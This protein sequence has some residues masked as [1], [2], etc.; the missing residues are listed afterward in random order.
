MSQTQNQDLPVPPASQSNE[1]QQGLLNLQRIMDNQLA[2]ERNSFLQ[3]RQMLDREIKELRKYRDVSMVKSLTVDNDSL[4]TENALLKKRLRN[5]NQEQSP[6]AQQTE[7]QSM[8][9]TMTVPTPHAPSQRTTVSTKAK[10][11]IKM[12]EEEVA[13]PEPEEPEETVQASG[14]PKDQLTLEDMLPREEEAQSEEPETEEPETEAAD[15]AEE[16]AAEQTEEPETEEPEAADEA[17]A[18]DGWELVYVEHLESGQYFW[19]VET[20][21][22]HDVVSPEEAGEV[23]GHIKTIKIRDQ[24][25]YV[26]TKDN[27]VYAYVVETGD[28]GDLCGSIVN[29]KFVKN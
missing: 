16:A 25:Y 1:F 5:Q 8:Y 13:V 24:H 26:D 4:R 28:I 17:E 21:N 19:D 10:P 12:K 29:R 18:D 3:A 11:T 20:G 15:E 2:G 27:N 22:L 7:Q 9:S 23:V 14:A 6:V